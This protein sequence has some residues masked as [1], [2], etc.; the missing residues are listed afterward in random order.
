MPTRATTCLPLL[1]LLTG[2]GAGAGPDY[3]PPVAVIRG[4]ITRSVVELPTEMYVSMGWITFRVTAL[5]AGAI[6]FLLPFEISQVTQD[7]R[8]ELGFPA[9]FEVAF[10]RLP[11]PDQFVFP[12]KDFM[13]IQGGVAVGSMMLYQDGDG[14]GHLDA[15]REG[16]SPSKDRWFHTTPEVAFMYIESAADLGG[17]DM[18]MARER[19]G[20]NL[21]TLPPLELPPAGYPCNL[22][23]PPEAQRVPPVV[24]GVEAGDRRAAAGGAVQP[25]PDRHRA[26]QRACHDA[27]HHR[28]QAGHDRRPVRCSDDRTAFLTR[29]RQF[30][31]TPCEQLVRCVK[32]SPCP[33]QPL[34]ECP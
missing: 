28:M 1:A 30:P 14:N 17:I 25:L 8:V 20:F 2:C 24:G 12:P 13:K 34:P 4:E 26:A 29:M 31:D 23:L 15:T 33:S 16:G 19:L 6:P 18:G 5:D 9:R 21:I 22:E 32:R 7:T 10:D 3:A 27:I 11:S